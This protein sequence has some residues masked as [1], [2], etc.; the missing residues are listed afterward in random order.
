MLTK[1]QATKKGEEFLQLV[2]S[3]IGGDWKLDVWENLGWHYMVY[4]GGM[5][6]WEYESGYDAMIADELIE[7]ITRPSG[8]PI[9]WSVCEKKFTTPK[10]ALEV[11]LAKAQS[12]VDKEVKVLN[13]NKNLLPCKK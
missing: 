13:Q 12:V 4:L 7:D 10:E 11:A 9:A 3:A 5:G 8:T 6:L 1:I 2:K